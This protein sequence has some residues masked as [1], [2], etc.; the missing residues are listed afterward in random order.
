MVYECTAPPVSLALIASSILSMIVCA[1]VVVISSYVIF[2]Y[3][4]IFVAG[5]PPIKKVGVTRR[6]R[7]KNA[8]D[9]KEERMKKEN[10]R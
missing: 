7:V 3:P 1:A 4:P 6:A 9:H 2:L 5:P 10:L 8:T